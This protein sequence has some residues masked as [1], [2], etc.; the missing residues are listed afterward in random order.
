MENMEEELLLNKTI[1]NECG[2]PLNLYSY[3]KNNNRNTNE[4][5]II[6]KLKCR[7]SNHRTINEIKFEDF[8]SIIKNNYNICKCSICNNFIN[9]SN[10]SYYNCECQKINCSKCIKEK[11]IFHKIKYNELQNKCLF[12]L[13][14]LSYFCKKC[15]KAMCKE[16]S[17]D[18][19]NHYTNNEI[20]QI[21]NFDSYIKNEINLLEKEQNELNNKLRILNKKINFNKFL[22]NQT[23][24][25]FNSYSLN[26][27][28]IEEEESERERE[29]ENYINIIYLDLKVNSDDQ[30]NIKD[31]K[32]DCKELE[33][34][35]INSNIILINDFDNFKILIKFFQKIGV[36]NKFILIISGRLS[37]EAINFIDENQYNNLF[38]Y[39]L[40]YTSKKSKEINI[41]TM[42]KY[43]RFY[44]NVC[45]RMKEII[46]YINESSSNF[47]NEKFNFYTSINNNKN[48]LYL[49][50]ELNKFYRNEELNKFYRN[51]NFFIIQNYIK[52]ENINEGI[53]FDL[54]NYFKIF[55]ELN[56]QN[57]ENIIKFYLKYNYFSRY[58][59]L[60]LNTKDILVYKKVGYFVGNLI[61]CLDQYGSKMDKEV[62]VDKNFYYGMQLN[63]I[64][65]LEFLKYKNSKFSF[66]YFLSITTKEKF[67]EFI[68]NRNISVEERK[69]NDLYSV[70]MNIKYIFNKDYKSGIYYINDLATFKDEEGY[71]LLPFTFMKI[72]NINIDSNNYCVDIDCEI[73]ENKLLNNL[74]NNKEEDFSHLKRGN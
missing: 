39:G 56:N 9:N 57:Y 27:N 49:Y 69:K 45:I 62:K 26:S 67:A 72:I 59:N 43:Q 18:D 55:L 65:V 17:C 16:C 33:T 74:K 2:L 41:K 64:E 63:I 51:D 12:H 38:I 68:S 10:D 19:I 1:C 73:S 25:F 11:G 37:E 21:N 14:E 20:N 48:D 60:L 53:K 7:N 5:E 47:K 44:K 66:P 42:E 40:I 29:K 31:V 28:K 24:Y 34:N 52:N 32:K 35:V 36:K 58:L 3:E 71:L 54:I 30:K 8:N 22:M 50:D 23:N 46:N 61:Y 70:I 4:E 13:E 6:I 15:K